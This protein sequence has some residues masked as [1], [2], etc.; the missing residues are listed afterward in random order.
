MHRSKVSQRKAFADFLA[1]NYL[2]NFFWALKSFEEHAFGG[3]DS[4]LE[5]MQRDVQGMV[6][7]VEHVVRALG[8]KAPKLYRMLRALWKDPAV[9]KLLT[10]EKTLAE[11]G[12]RPDEWSQKWP[13]VKEKIDALREEGEVGQVVADLIMAIRLRG[14]VHYALP[15]DD[16][17][18]LERIFVSLMRAAALTFLEVHRQ[19]P[20][21]DDPEESSEVA[22]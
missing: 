17:L 6:V 19:N 20:A 13:Q 15:E 11:Q 1:D 14:A 5:G 9:S 3:H 10:R 4:Y 7:C 21:T 16:Q 2:D 8:G 18:E 12:Y 22:A